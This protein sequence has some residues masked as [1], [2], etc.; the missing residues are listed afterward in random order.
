MRLIV[1]VCFIMGLG[2]RSKWIFLV[3]T[4]LCMIG[5]TG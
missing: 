2:V 5:D 3:W 4:L 1:R